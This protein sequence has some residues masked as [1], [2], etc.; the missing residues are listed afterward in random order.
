MA[1]VDGRQTPS[2]VALWSGSGILL[3]EMAADEKTMFEIYR[4]TDYNRGFHSI[5]YTDLDEHVRDNEIARAASGETLFTGY[6][7]DSRKDEAKSAVAAI[8][9]ELNEMDEDEA[10]M[11]ADEIERRL[12]DFLVP[13]P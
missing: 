10:D 7:D 11:P 8:L 6:I 13:A 2:R 1:L 9:D 3:S 5:F 12:R 4:E